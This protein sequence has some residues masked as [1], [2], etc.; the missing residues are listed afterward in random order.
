MEKYIT[1]KQT[2]FLQTLVTERAE[3]LGI[4]NPTEQSV[5]DY[6]GSC[7]LFTTKDASEMISRLLAVPA[8]KPKVTAPKVVVARDISH[9]DSVV[10][11]VTR[12]ITNKFSKDCSLC[13]NEVETG[14]G[15]A[16]L[17]GNVW[18][19]FHNN[20]ECPD[21]K[22]GSPL[23]LQIEQF[24][25]DN[26]VGMGDV[27]FALPSHTGNNDLDFYALVQSHR[28]TGTVMVL[29][30]VLGGRTLE[31][32]PVV[33]KSEAERVLNALRAMSTEESDEA[34]KRFADELG[35]CCL[36]G[37]TLTDEESRARGMGADCAEKNA[38]ELSLKVL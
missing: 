5:I 8:P 9:T 31:S 30:R 27:Y 33:R 4:K 3:I 24:V 21:A 15:I 22:E 19:T 36:C 20:G 28:K 6:I 26:C 35:R 32:S 12:I 38:L 7:K 23:H 16:V 18:R 34:M 11:S 17:D 25:Q 37:R 13:G 29:R 2:K 1:E 14:K 10:Q